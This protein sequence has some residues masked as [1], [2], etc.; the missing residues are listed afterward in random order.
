MACSAPLLM[1]KML[2]QA[3]EAEALKDPETDY[4]DHLQLRLDLVLTFAELG[5]HHD[6]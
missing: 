6:C 1:R 2:L 4:Y 5:A 3:T